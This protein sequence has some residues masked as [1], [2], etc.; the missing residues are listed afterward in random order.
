LDD[1]DD[2]TDDDHDDGG[3]A[4]MVSVGDAADDGESF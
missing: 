3:P 1:W 2:T 4:E